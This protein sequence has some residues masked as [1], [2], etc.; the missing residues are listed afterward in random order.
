MSLK[1]ETRLW[2]LR[3]V[4]EIR[5]TWCLWFQ[6]QLIGGWVCLWFQ[7]QGPCASCSCAPWSCTP[8]SLHCLWNQRHPS[9]PFTAS[10]IRV[11]LPLQFT[12]SEIRGIKCLC[13]Q[14]HVSDFIDASL[15]L[16]TSK[17]SNFR[18]LLITLATQEIWNLFF[19]I[20]VT[21]T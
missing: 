20:I 4:T 14:R 2:N 12:T 13:F 8:W 1:S 18:K 15:I 10:E 11:T 19:R 21:Q 16:E 9:P 5:D 6:R 17:F 7:R 3:H